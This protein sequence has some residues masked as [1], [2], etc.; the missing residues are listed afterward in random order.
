LLRGVSADHTDFTDNRKALEA[1][2]SL[3]FL[4]G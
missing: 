2:V 4:C 3:L 1:F